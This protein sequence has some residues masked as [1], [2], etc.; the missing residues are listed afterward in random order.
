M[1]AVVVLLAA[2]GSWHHESVQELVHVERLTP[3][4]QGV[5][6]RS[7]S[8]RKPALRGR[9]VHSTSP[10][11]GGLTLLDGIETN[12][13]FGHTVAGAGDLN[14]DGYA[15]LAVGAFRMGPGSLGQVVVF[16]GSKQ[17]VDTNRFQ[18]IS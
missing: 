4:A 1:L 10:L 16:W 17:G 7:L 11:A 18:I 9:R 3:G 2:R 5:A 12:A 15:D 13:F 14:G 8:S 6:D